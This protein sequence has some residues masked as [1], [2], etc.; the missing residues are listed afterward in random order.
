MIHGRGTKIPHATRC[1][2]KK[3]KKPHQTPHWGYHRE[4]NCHQ[5]VKLKPETRASGCALRWA[6]TSIP[7]QQALHTRPAL[8]HLSSL[9]QTFLQPQLVVLSNAPVASGCRV[10]ACRH[11]PIHMY[12][13]VPVCVHF[14]L[15]LSCMYDFKSFLLSL[16]SCLPT[17]LEVAAN[18]SGIQG[19]GHRWE[20][21]EALI[22]HNPKLQI[23]KL[24]LQRRCK[25]RDLIRGKECSPQGGKGL[26]G[27][28]LTGRS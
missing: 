27:L 7:M 15:V 2:Q 19:T 11:V 4:V 17:F 12:V 23:P 22:D 14:Q 3:K 13:L 10:C 1:G 6:S 26:A 28:G 8:C 5:V 25:L 20:G 21:Q 9:S 16:F 18:E 24:H